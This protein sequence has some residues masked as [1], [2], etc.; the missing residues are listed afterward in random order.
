MTQNEVYSQGTLARIH[1]PAL[2]KG[3]HRHGVGKAKAINRASGLMGVAEAACRISSGIAFLKDIFLST[4]NN[5]QK[6]K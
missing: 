6:S 4:A 1:A 3:G 5:R 2:A